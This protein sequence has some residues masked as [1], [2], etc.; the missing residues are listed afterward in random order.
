MRLLGHSDLSM[1]TRYAHI[2]DDEMRD[3]VMGL[4]VALVNEIV[5][6]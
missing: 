4:N 5:D 2:G 6:T 3:A 1:V